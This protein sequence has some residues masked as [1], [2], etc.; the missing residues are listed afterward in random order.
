M[1]L[2][3]CP[4]FGTHPAHKRVVHDHPHVSGGGRL[5]SRKYEP[6]ELV[7]S[8]PRDKIACLVRVAGCGPPPPPSGYRQGRSLNSDKQFFFESLKRFVP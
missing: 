4:L 5:G 7:A 1:L 3:R 8:L 6:R 2:I